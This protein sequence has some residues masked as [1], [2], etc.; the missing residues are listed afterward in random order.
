MSG[1]PRKIK[2]E[3]YLTISSAKRKK[4]H[5]RQRSFHIG[6][7][8]NRSFGEKSIVMDGVQRVKDHE[9]GLPA[10]RPSMS[11]NARYL[12]R[13]AVFTVLIF[14]IFCLLRPGAFLSPDNLS[15]M[16]YQFPEFA[17]LALAM[18]PT[19]L[20][21]GIDLSVVSVANLCG[22]L[23]A[24]IMRSGPPQFMLVAA[25]VALLV[26]TLCGVFNGIL[27]AACRLPAIVATLGTLQLFA[28]ISI[29][30]TKGS[31]I[32]GIPSAY[33]NVGNSSVLGIP[34]PLLIFTLALLI[35]E[36]V[37]VRT[38]LGK[39]MRLY[40]TNS[41]AAPFAGIPTF[42]VLVLTY[43]LSGI[44]AACAGLV[45]L[46]R[47]NSA[48]ADYGTS[49]LLLSVLINIL[50][51]VNPNGGSGTVFGLVL[52]VL[53]LQFVSSGLNLLSVNNFA[54]DLLNGALLVT[55]MIANQLQGRIRSTRVRT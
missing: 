25:A 27:V 34:V 33:A 43:A 17:I 14:V 38:P 39:Q 24:F 47:A 50:A 9:K 6:F 44:T 32:T 20:T 37:T 16:A 51:G 3:H 22:I 54:R 45:I 29:I 48:N 41:R 21:G 12:I 19:M 31:S 35:I 55:V 11:G 5:E 8:V 36:V 46:S 52:A 28:G 53:S 49:Y 4:K 1:R 30:L 26:G 10:A 2:G 23:A 15:S 40:G 18:H 13:L 7:H 42:R